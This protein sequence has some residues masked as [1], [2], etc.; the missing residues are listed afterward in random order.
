MSDVTNHKIPLDN[1]PE[2][3]S[4]TSMLPEK[5]SVFKPFQLHSLELKNRFVMAPMTRNFSPRGIPGP[6]SASY[7][8]KRALGGV[9]LIITEGTTIDHKAS[10]GYQDVPVLYGAKA[11][12]GWKTVVDSVHETDTKIFPQLWHVGSVREAGMEP[13]PKIPGY[14][15]SAIRHPVKKEGPP[16]VAMSQKDIEEV[17]AAYAKAAKDAMLLGFDGIEIHGAHGYLIDQFFWEKTNKRTDSYGGSL[18]NRSRFAAQ[19]VAGIRASTS[20]QFPIMFRMSQWKMGDYSAKMAKT[21]AELEIILESLVQAGVDIFH[22]S[23]RRYYENEF[24]GSDLNL[25]GWV[26]KITGKATCTVGSIGLK[27]DF[28]RAF[29]GKSAT[30]LPLDE[31]YQRMANNEFDLAAVGRCLISDPDWVTKIKE[32]REDQIKGFDANDLKS[33]T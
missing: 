10:N 8:K 1:G 3:Q 2:L 18:E 21:P 19:I 26:K 5:N 17:V 20:P 33:L 6:Q 15:A 14:S 29:L 11:L 24:D 30:T 7:Y 13:D 4:A 23:Q 22:C 12:A 9:G 28:L 27:G 32:D 31:L 25:A 16:P